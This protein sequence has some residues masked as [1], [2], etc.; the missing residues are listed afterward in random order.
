MHYMRKCYT[1]L[2]LTWLHLGVC[3]SLKCFQFKVNLLK[4]HKIHLTWAKIVYFS[5]VNLWKKCKIFQNVFKT[6]LKYEKVKNIGFYLY[7]L[8]LEKQKLKLES[9]NF[10]IYT[11]KRSKDL[12][13][14]LIFKQFRSFPDNLVAF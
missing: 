5:V 6:D 14:P 12:Y 7:L 13:I 2:Y 8:H 4:L 1:M 11:P 3:N 10:V 9:F